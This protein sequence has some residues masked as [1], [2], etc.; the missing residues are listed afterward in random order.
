MEARCLHVA[1]RPR[2]MWVTA[3][4]CCVG[5]RLE[6]TCGM[7]FP[8]TGTPDRIL[9]LGNGP[10]GGPFLM[11]I[12]FAKLGRISASGRTEGRGVMPLPSVR[13]GGLVSNWS[14]RTVCSG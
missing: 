10:H 2:V 13:L 3:D 6:A 1:R 8:A 5:E 7:L 12:R 14:L 11:S 9:N 4:G